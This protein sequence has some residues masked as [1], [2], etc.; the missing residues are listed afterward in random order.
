MMIQ[1]EFQ[2]FQRGRYTTNLIAI[3]VVL[4][5]NLANELGPLFLH[6]YGHLLVITGYKWAYTFY[7]WC[8]KYL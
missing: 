2:I 8:Y 1:S 6:S 7:K 5:A 3:V 4:F